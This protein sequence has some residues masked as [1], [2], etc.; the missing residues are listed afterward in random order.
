MQAP[1]KVTLLKRAT[2]APLSAPVATA[3]EAVRAALAGA[4][5]RERSRGEALAAAR[6]DALL[7]ALR[8]LLSGSLHVALEKAVAA[9]ADALIAAVLKVEGPSVKACGE[10]VVPAEGADG[11]VTNGINDMRKAFAAAFEEALLDSMEGSVRGMLTGVSNAVDC[12]AET[13]VAKPAADAAVL[14]L[15]RA[16]DDVRA[17]ASGIAAMSADLPAH[18]GADDDDDIVEA[19]SVDKDEAALAEVSRAL[20]EGRIKDALVNS[21]GHSAVVRGKAVSGALDSGIAPEEVLGGDE[22]GLVTLRMLSG[23]CGLLASD[24]ADR[25]DARLAW[26]YEAVMGIED[27]P[28]DDVDVD[29]CIR[30]LE[31]A[32]ENLG[33][34][35]RGVDG[36]SAAEARQA[37]MLV[38]ALKSTI[39]GLTAA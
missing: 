34:V 15:R 37:K 16:A 21:V 20:A 25:T 4:L 28:S 33:S 10:K 7:R 17:A 22:D 3:G 36:A 2:P 38:R 39:A 13:K 5:A 27:A 35:Q 14:A 23:L 1:P 18:G 32:A 30:L 9:E 19:K 24:L 12:A 6:T 8:D 29:S 26:L 11:E 31:S